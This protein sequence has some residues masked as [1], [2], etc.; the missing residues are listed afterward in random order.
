MSGPGPAAPPAVVCW[1]GRGKHGPALRALPSP[2]GGEGALFPSTLLLGMGSPPGL[3]I[4][5]PLS[6]SSYLYRAWAGATMVSVLDV[7][8]CLVGRVQGSGL[9]LGEALQPLGGA[10]PTE[11]LLVSVSIPMASV[12]AP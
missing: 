6:F 5:G 4:E 7:L 8:C 2:R 3:P 9:A 10:S 1:V 11:G 12:G